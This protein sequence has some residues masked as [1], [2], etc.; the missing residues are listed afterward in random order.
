MAA[1]SPSINDTFNDLLL[2]LA[3][4]LYVAAYAVNPSEAVE[5]SKGTEQ[6]ML[7]NC[8]INSALL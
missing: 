7:K 1:M 4:N 2:K 5:P 3:N 6:E 8:V